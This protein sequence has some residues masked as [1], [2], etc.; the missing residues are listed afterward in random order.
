[1]VNSLTKP[2]LPDLSEQLKSLS[3]QKRSVREMRGLIM[4]LEDAM[5]AIPGHMEQAD[6]DTRHHFGPGTYVRELRIPAGV[7]LTGKIHSASHLNILAQGTITVWTEEGMKTL[8]APQIIT[9]QAAIKRVGHAHTDTTWITVHANPDNEHD[10]DKVTDRIA[11]DTFD[12]AYSW[13]SRSF[14][15]A[16]RFLG[17]S[18]DEVKA[19][20][21]DESDVIICPSGPYGIEIKE[22]KIHGRG[23]FATREFEPFE[24][25]CPARIGAMRTP[26]GRYC[27]HSGYPNAEM[28]MRDSS[29]VYLYALLPIPCGAEIFND[30]YFDFERT[31]P[32]GLDGGRLCLSQG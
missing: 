23:V 32:K 3:S 5:R 17:F 28:R 13:S 1:M 10:I 2:Q 7:T 27:N 11:S 24:F 16:I 30:Y 15:D 20:S 21:E 25:I 12:E 6:F 9:S 29:S 31:R 22:S 19:V 14:D 18:E 26:A 4:S 8:Q